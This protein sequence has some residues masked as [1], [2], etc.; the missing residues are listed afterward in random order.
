MVN[1]SLE[2]HRTSELFAG[3]NVMTL[4]EWTNPY[5]F[6]LSKDPIFL[7]GEE[8]LRPVQSWDR[9]KVTEIDLLVSGNTPA[10]GDAA[11]ETPFHSTV[12]FSRRAS[13]GKPRKPSSLRSSRISAI[14]SARLS[15]HTSIV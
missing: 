14:A 8:P 1:A 11:A 7:C 13:A 5:K 2:P 12:T 3:A 4:V 10:Y 6:S 15:R 9:T